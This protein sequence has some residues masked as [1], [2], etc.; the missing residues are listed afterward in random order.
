MEG[1]ATY[2]DGKTAKDHAVTVRLSD[3]RLTFAGKTVVPQLWRTESIA[4]V[5][6]YSGHGP[7]RLVHSER[8]GERLII[9]PGTFA[10][11]LA[12]ALPGLGS[13]PLHSSVGR[14]AG[15]ILGSMAALALVGYAVFVYAPSHVAAML[16]AKVTAQMGE[17]ME[18]TLVEN[19]K[20]CSSDAGD[21]AL[22]TM[23]AK[24]AEGDIKLPPLTIHIYDMSLVNA[25][26]L[27][28]GRIVLTRGLL[29]KAGSADEVAGVLA[30]EM[31]H[32]SLLHPE[33]QLVRL[34]GVDLV[35]K[36]FS[37][38]TSGNTAANMAGLAAVL[39]SSRDAERAADDY[40]RT[41]MLAA[42]VDPTGLRRFF[43]G[44]VE[45]KPS[46]GD[47]PLSRIGNVF[48]THPGLEE[49]IHDFQ[50]LPPGTVV[51]PVLSDDEWK[52]LQSICKAG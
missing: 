44:L 52:A 33:A 37:G 30:H 50:P 13:K 43:E 15:W 32:A 51:Q 36:V 34:M 25:F 14:I 41:T 7:L 49:R 9:M 12:A 28:G 48:A 27:T 29:E 18:R 42:H 45:H 38:G 19:A 11:E 1:S 40:A 6:H 21:K 35:L 4:S 10:A 2:F 24:L 3:A 5:E 8:P 16:P 47:S 46:D 31:G 23:V 22:A 39:R 20:S 17:E 26:T